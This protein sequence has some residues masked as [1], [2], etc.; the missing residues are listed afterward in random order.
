[1][2]RKGEMMWC[3]GLNGVGFVVVLCLWIVF[4]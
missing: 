1:V 3:R 4:G 2:G